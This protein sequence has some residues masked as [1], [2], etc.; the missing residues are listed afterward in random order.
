VQITHNEGKFMLPGP[1]YIY[2][3]PSCKGLLERRSISS[4]N[5]SRAKFRSDGQM[6]APMLP[7]TPL[8]VA[9]PKCKASIFWPSSKEVDSY[10]TNVMTGFLGADPPSV[11]TLAFRAEMK[12]KKLRYKDVFGY[13]QASS[14]QIIEFIRNGSAES[15]FELPLRLLFWQRVNDERLEVGRIGLNSDEQENLQKLLLLID[16]K[17][18]SHRLQKAEIYRQLGQFNDAMR[19][20]DYN[21]DDDISARA[22]QLMQTAERKDTLPFLFVGH[23]DEYEY[24]T[25]WRARRYVSEDPKTFN[26]AELN[27]PVFKISNRNWWVKVLGMLCHNWALIEK[28]DD[29]SATV[30]FFQDQGGNERPAIIDSLSFKGVAEANDGLRKN[31]FRLLKTYPGPWMDCEPKGFIYDNRGDLNLV[32]S[33]LGYWS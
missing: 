25:D 6:R 1:T 30:Y 5:T 11:E 29:D 24:E 20:L 26:F 19:I 33:Q 22:E 10:E 31:G 13:E 9:C 15:S 4:G 28:N 18:D 3:C 17:T 23:D 8:L 12:A 7:T 16:L 27:P 21:F 32:Y 2:E 14:A